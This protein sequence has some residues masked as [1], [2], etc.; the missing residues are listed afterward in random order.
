MP[1]IDFP[2]AAEPEEEKKSAKPSGGREWGDY[3]KAFASGAAGMAGG[4][5]RLFEG[6]NTPNV[7]RAR[8]YLEDTSESVR[9]SMSEAG[10]KASQREVLSTGENSIWQNPGDIP[11]MLTESVAPS[12]ALS[13]V[14]GMAG[15]ALGKI[16]GAVGSRAGA[17]GGVAAAGY[18]MGAGGIEQE[19]SDVIKRAKPED[20]GDRYRQLTGAGARD[21]DARDQI[22]R[23]VASGYK[24]AGGAFSAVLNTL[25]PVGQT[26]R[27]LGATGSY[28]GAIKGGITRAAGREAINEGIDETGT[29]Y[30]GEAAMEDR[31]GRDI[32]WGGLAERGAKGMLTGALTGG[33]LRAVGGR[34]REYQPGDEVSSK[35]QP[36]ERA[37]LPGTGTQAIP[38]D[39]AIIDR[40]TAKAQ[41]MVRAAG[42]VVNGPGAMGPFQETAGGEQYGPAAPRPQGATVYGAPAG[43]M[44]ETAG[45]EMYGPQT[46][47]RDP[48]SSYQQMGPMPETAGGQQY[49]PVR[50]GEMNGPTDNPA[51]RVMERIAQA[52]GGV[53]DPVQISAYLSQSGRSVPPAEVL[54]SLE[55]MVEQGL[56]RQRTLPGT[57]G[58]PTFSL[59][60]QA[61]PAPEPGRFAITQV[62]DMQGPQNRPPMRPTSVVSR[63]SAPM[64]PDPETTGRT[65]IVSRVSGPSAPDGSLS[66]IV[67]GQSVV[68]RQNAPDGIPL[69]MAS[70]TVDLTGA[71]SSKG[72]RGGSGGG[73]RSGSG[74]AGVTARGPRKGGPGGASAPAANSGVKPKKAAPKAE[75]LKAKVKAKPVKAKPVPK[76]KPEAKKPVAPQQVDAA[77]AK[78]EATAP[79]KARRSYAD[80]TAR[81][82]MASRPAVEAKAP[83]G[84]KPAKETTPAPVSREATAPRAVEK[85]RQSAPKSMKGRDADKLLSEL[86]DLAPK[87]K[88]GD[89]DAGVVNG[90]IRTVYNDGLPKTKTSRLLVERRVDSPTV[91]RTTGGGGLIGRMKSERVEQAGPFAEKVSGE[92][93]TLNDW[94]TEL[95]HADRVKVVAIL[96]AWR[97]QYGKTLDASGKLPRVTWLTAADRVE[98]KASEGLKNAATAAQLE[99]LKNKGVGGEAKTKVSDQE[100]VLQVRSA[101]DRRSD[102]KISEKDLDLL[103]GTIMLDAKREMDE[104]G[105]TGLNMP[106]LW[107]TAQKR[108]SAIKAVQQGDAK[109]DP[110][111]TSEWFYQEMVGA[112]PAARAKQVDSFETG[113]EKNRRRKSPEAKPSK[114]QPTEQDYLDRAIAGGMKPAEAQADLRRKIVVGLQEAVRDVVDGELNVARAYVRRVRMPLQPSKSDALPNTPEGKAY[115]RALAKEEID[116]DEKAKAEE[117]RAAKEARRERQMEDAGLP[118]P[119]REMERGAYIG[120]RRDVDFYQTF[121]KD[122]NLKRFDKLRRIGRKIAAKYMRAGL[123]V[124]E[125]AQAVLDYDALAPKRG[126]AKPDR[127]GALEVIKT[128]IEEAAKVW[129]AT[130]IGRLADRREDFEKRTPLGVFNDFA[131]DA[132]EDPN[133]TPE[134]AAARLNEMAKEYAERNKEFRGAN[135]ARNLLKSTADP[136]ANFIRDLMLLTDGGTKELTYQRPWAARKAFYLQGMSEEQVARFEA[137]MKR[138]DKLPNEMEYAEAVL[139]FR[140]AEA[141]V[142]GVRKFKTKADKDNFRNSVNYKGDRNGLGND[143]QPAILPQ[144]KREIEDGD[145]SPNTDPQREADSRYKAMY[146][147]DPSAEITPS[148][149]KRLSEAAVRR[150]QRVTALI[151]QDFFLRHEIEEDLTLDGK[152]QGFEGADL[153]GD[154]PFSAPTE[155]RYTPDEAMDMLFGTGPLKGF[156]RI[157]DAMMQKISAS[158]A[159]VFFVSA[160]EMQGWTDAYDMK[161]SVGLY[162]R[163]R[164]VIQIQNGLPISLAREALVHELTHAVTMNGLDTPLIKTLGEE[165]LGEARAAGLADHAASD[166]YELVTFA[167]TSPDAAGKLG[168]MPVSEALAAKLGIA[169]E[170]TLWDAFVALVRRVLGLSPRDGVT[171]L[172]AVIQL[173][174]TAAEVNGPPGG[175]GGLKPAA[176]VNSGLTNRLGTAARNGQ[177]NAG[178]KARRALMALSTKID[179][180]TDYGRYFKWAGDTVGKYLR[181]DRANDPVAQVE[182]AGAYK[183]GLV[184][185]LESKHRAFHDLLANHQRLRPREAEKLG[186]LIHDATT[187]NIDFTS[188][189]PPR[190]AGTKSAQQRLQMDRYDRLRADYL[191]MGKAEQ[192]IVDEIKRVIRTTQENLLLARATSLVKTRWQY[193]Q[194]DGVE[195]LP[196]QR[197]LESIAADAAN[198]QVSDENRA[199]LGEGVIEHVEH[200][201]RNLKRMAFYVP[202]LRH[203]EWIVF[204]ERTDFQKEEYFA[205]EAAAVARAKEIEANGGLV[206]RIGQRSFDP[207]GKHVRAVD[208]GD[209]KDL[210]FKWLI[211]TQPRVMEAYDTKAEAL[212]AAETLKK[213]G[214][215]LVQVEP[216]ETGLYGKYEQLTEKQNEVITKALQKVTSDEDEQKELIRAFRD[217]AIGLMPGAD[218][219][220]STLSRKNV[221]G[222]SEDHVRTMA[223]YIGST[224]Q[225]M[226]GLHFR[227]YQQAAYMAMDD[228]IKGTRKGYADKDNE[229]RLHV[230]TELKQR[231][232]NADENEG[233]GPI[234][235]AVARVTSVWF[236]A[237]PSYTLL[238]LTQ[239]IM[240]GFPTLTRIFSKASVGEIGSA[241]KAAHEDIGGLGVMG[242]SGLQGAKRAID[243][244]RRKDA[245]AVVDM[246]G[247]VKQN[248]RESG[249]K[250]AEQLVDLLDELAQLGRIDEHAGMEVQRAAKGE[251]NA[252]AR[253]FAMVEEVSRAF[254]AAAE[255]NNRAIMAVAAWRLAKKEGRSD[256]DAFLAAEDALVNSQGVYNPENT[257]RFFQQN[258]VTMPFFVF[259]KYVQLVYMQLGRSLYDSLKGET[260]EVRHAAR[261]QFGYMM[262][263][264]AAAAGAFGLPVEPFKIAAGLV[265]FGMG[266]D[267]PFDWEVWATKK[268]NDLF[269][270]EVTEVL[271]RGLPRLINLDVSGRLGIDSLIF[272]KELE[273]YKPKTF[274]GYVG[275]T[276][277]GAPGGILMG[278]LRARELARNDA[279]WGKVAAAASPKAVRDVVNAWGMSEEGMTDSKGNRI[280]EGLMTT[281]DAFWKAIGFRSGTEANIQDERRY[282]F[283]REKRMT[284]DRAR[285]HAQW[286]AAEESGD[287]EQLARVRTR[288]EEFNSEFPAAEVN[289]KSKERSQRAREAREERS[290]YGVPQR[291]GSAPATLYN[292]PARKGDTS[293]EEATVTGARLA[294]P[295]APTQVSFDR[296]SDPMYDA[297]IRAEGTDK[298]GDPYNEVL[299]YG[300]Y[301]SPPRPLVEM[302]LAEVYDFGQNVIRRNHRA[303]GHPGD[304]SGRGSSALGAFQIV[305]S[306][307]EAMMDEAGLTWEDKFSPDN[308]RR[309]ARVIMRRQGTDAW[310]GFKR[311]PQERM[312]ARRMFNVYPE[313]A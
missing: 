110:E 302:S 300:A 47:I 112:A 192:K 219:Q 228:E 253:A 301:G 275:E 206:T 35:V 43:P 27:K 156:E 294:P 161:T 63:Q 56:L 256:K 270:K 74:G 151:G 223:R 138:R 140:K 212:A 291:K 280:D 37:A 292:L 191:K 123:T 180:A 45:G 71:L 271:T 189:K 282:Q 93:V 183:A 52:N 179:L 216:R 34:Q 100:M 113:L 102:G 211:L 164:N 66:P 12:I 186:K 197:M 174:K 200:D 29:G 306:T 163:R 83:E 118:D 205:D 131:P 55:P 229:I 99:K 217:T 304:P 311:Y 28:K 173:G 36:D 251:G 158:G 58:T 75:A 313:V 42:T 134:K 44:P 139:R 248:I 50:G 10:R 69:G 117:A 227:P 204:G 8:R 136:Y 126:P 129:D 293:E 274:W 220:H 135:N 153:D 17:T 247:R 14:G 64:G 215:A 107:D 82:Q 246:L 166:V 245:A 159:K 307:L 133:R 241:M 262:A 255:V 72:G 218:V 289:E 130:A 224:A 165:L 258:K 80:P 150:S 96:R 46:P 202:K 109:S 172:D 78:E 143:G 15:G 196:D 162:F 285:L 242:G 104:N 16:A 87:G 51:Y 92:P 91:R 22:T 108:M 269:G 221:L 3:P 309:L 41:E 30:A 167:F 264:H 77:P 142:V 176:L 259:K 53:V 297:I 190:D 177:I 296:Q 85:I 295:S 303:A 195:G 203:G 284:R 290:M 49:G 170:N 265:A 23:E 231:D 31:L 145:L 188:D 305:G 94:F 184:K 79:A 39:G 235:Q 124:P 250:D 95:T 38:T 279:G 70:P 268:L 18:G 312:T 272:M 254:P 128:Q 286:I 276:V 157:N 60:P 244:Y 234:L 198:E 232:A 225:Y 209:R 25:G 68:S 73:G 194:R 84:A 175:G 4:V 111:L 240:L 181:L 207:D 299:G 121:D 226:G 115:A 5:A 24:E 125:F 67:P 33:G 97:K 106:K 32:D 105:I 21:Q 57:R 146:A 89:I 103:V 40:A 148:E 160:E 230:M 48:V 237:S 178:P 11:L 266:E 127:R 288:I 281:G 26:L 287:N 2:A 257:A 222:A 187:W 9:G 213:Q 233:R 137:Q 62:G 210:S 61:P 119:T 298:R 243:K 252:I 168:S 273:D 101:F 19:V 263:A 114:R 59:V 116:A 267:E 283:D 147:L 120:K 208:R 54:R 98:K 239:P 132:E 76:V 182:K 308:Q 149:F 141:G 171:M 144:V 1:F 122:G 214:I 88:D 249:A 260:P 193:A 277:G 81:V 86:N 90:V 65:G 13:A 152:P 155:E 154:M 6:E 310:E 201:A 169:R 238:Q 185:V 261:R 20:L 199:W 7:T 278:M 236:L